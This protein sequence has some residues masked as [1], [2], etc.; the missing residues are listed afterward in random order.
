VEITGISSQTTATAETKETLSSTSPTRDWQEAAFSAV[1]GYPVSVSFHQDRMVIGGSRDLTNR[2]WLSKSADLFNFDLG[3]AEDDEAIEFAILSDQVNAIR[4]VFSGRHL[5]VFTSGAEWMVTG[6]PLT[7]SNIQLKRQTRVG[8]PIHHSI[9]P[10]DV[11]G[12]SLFISRSGSELREFLFTDTE[13]AYQAHDL[14]VLSDEMMRDPREQD[15]NSMD[16]IMYLVNAD[17]TMASVTVFRPEKVTAWSLLKTHGVI[18]SIAV[19]GKDVYILVKRGESYRVERLDTSILTDAAITLSV[20]EGEDAKTDWDG[21]DHLNGFRVDVIADGIVRNPLDVT[22]GRIQLSQPASSLQIGL[23]YTHIIEPLPAYQPGGTGV[24]QG[25]AVRLVKATFRLLETA[26]LSVDTG[27]GLRPLPFKTF[28]HGTLESPIT[29]ITG[30]KT[31]RALGWT[32]GEPVPLWRIE[33]SD[34]LPCT[35]LSVL[36]EIS[37]NG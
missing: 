18:R 26:A 16:R 3:E 2:L 30:D 11:D 19:V 15:F 23:S 29:P 25:A 1:R 7:P 32:R 37:A 8:S 35:I 24:T 34:P 31:V 12:A 4:A 14:A 36:T 9:Q 28:G 6:D 10:R 27:Q 17:G 33:Q 20:E 5:Q 21:L 13:Q 22:E